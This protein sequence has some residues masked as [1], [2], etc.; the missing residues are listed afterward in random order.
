MHNN[1]WVQKL[2]NAPGLAKDSDVD[3]LYKRLR[4]LGY[5]AEI[6]QITS[7]KKN[8]KVT[9]AKN[10][11]LSMLPEGSDDVDGRVKGTAGINQLLSKAEVREYHSFIR[12]LQ[13]DFPKLNSG[14][15]VLFLR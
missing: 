9:K 13:E 15:P 8:L 1:R 10:K 4:T 5:D 11:V 12:H 14:A 6:D 7:S 3:V 2:G